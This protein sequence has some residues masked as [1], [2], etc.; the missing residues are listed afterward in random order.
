MADLP[1]E[2]MREE[3]PFTFC[4]VDMF[5]HF[6]VKNSCQE[7]KQYGALYICL[8]SRAIHIELT[9]SLNTDPF[10]ICLTG[11]IGRTGDVCLIRSDNGSNFIGILAELCQPF[12]EIDHSRISNYLEEHGGKRINWKRILYLQV[13][14]GEFGNDKVGVLE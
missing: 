9:Y 5:G 7:I 1:R 6:V 3:A 8:S 2:K 4:G 13:T 10:I 12:Q 11:F 14:W